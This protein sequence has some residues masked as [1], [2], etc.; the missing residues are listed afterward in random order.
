[1]QQDESKQM[2]TRG[3]LQTV[4]KRMDAAL[5]QLDD[6]DMLD[7]PILA[8]IVP[9]IESAVNITQTHST[10]LDKEQ[11]APTIQRL[12]WRDIKY[13]TATLQGMDSRTSLTYSF[14][15]ALKQLDSDL[16]HLDDT[17]T[18]N[19]SILAEI[20]SL[21]TRA[22]DVAQTAA[23][24]TTSGNYL[25]LLSEPRQGL[26]TK[27][28]APMHPRIPSSGQI[29]ANAMQL[30]RACEDSTP[31]TAAPSIRRFSRTRSQP[32]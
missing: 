18:L 31:D 16:N 5:T 26:V 21:I 19:S 27:A 4:L 8:Q 25:P 3:E 10:Q 29:L 20:I 13:K 14:K 24:Q 32:Y 6:S 28:T 1:M 2:Y 17:D 15:H 7:T 23:A 12:S 9:L 11:A 22:A 30:N